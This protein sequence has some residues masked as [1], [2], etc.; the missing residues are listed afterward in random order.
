[1]TRRSSGLSWLP[2][3]PRAPVL[4]SFPFLGMLGILRDDREKIRRWAKFSLGILSLSVL[5]AHFNRAK[6]YGVLLSAPWT[7]ANALGSGGTSDS[8][9]WDSTTTRLSSWQQ[10]IIPK[11]RFTTYVYNSTYNVRAFICLNTFCLNDKWNFSLCMACAGE[12]A[13]D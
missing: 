8:A 10:S 2:R 12:W 13:M 7:S 3:L 1:M 11:L 9:L 6:D 4:R 5:L